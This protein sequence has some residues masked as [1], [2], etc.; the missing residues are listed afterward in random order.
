MLVI[1]F[2]ATGRGVK[3]GVRQH[4]VNARW[5][6]KKRGIDGGRTPMQRYTL[7]AKEP[8]KD[9]GIASPERACRAK[10]RP[11]KGGAIAPLALPLTGRDSLELGA[12]FFGA[13]VF[14]A[15]HRLAATGCGGNG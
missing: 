12:V 15:A 4:A 14:S 2:N 3:K 5:R 10:S 9:W 8:K 7:K 6:E 13:S 1:A 11:V